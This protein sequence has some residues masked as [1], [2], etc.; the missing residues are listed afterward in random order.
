MLLNWNSKFSFLNFIK[1]AINNVKNIKKRKSKIKINIS[2][3]FI[4]QRDE[5]K[6]I[7][8]TMKIIIEFFY[9]IDHFK[10]LPSRS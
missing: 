3:S 7:F 4:M 1:Q 9:I 10:H 6:S 8:S 5:I 2:T